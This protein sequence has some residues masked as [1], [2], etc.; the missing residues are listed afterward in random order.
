MPTSGH[1]NGNGL[2]FAKGGSLKISDKSQVI[3]EFEPFY[4]HSRE[5]LSR[6]GN[7]FVSLYFAESNT[8]EILGDVGSDHPITIKSGAPAQGR[9][10]TPRWNFRKV[11]WTV[12]NE[13]LDQTLS[14]AKLIGY[15]STKAFTC[16]VLAA[17]RR[18]ILPGVIRKYSP[19]W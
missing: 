2:K 10:S 11:N 6:P 1:S 13:R 16:A 3:R 14:N 18:E 4:L 8:K 9:D 19:I 7:A 17:A 15:L 12:L 5:G